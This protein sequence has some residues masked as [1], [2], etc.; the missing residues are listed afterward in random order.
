MEDSLYSC[1]IKESAERGFLENESFLTDF[2]ILCRAQDS[3]GNHTYFTMASGDEGMP[4]HAALGLLE[5]FKQQAIYMM[6]AEPF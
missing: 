3:D 6:N 1:I 4:M 2:L 5:F